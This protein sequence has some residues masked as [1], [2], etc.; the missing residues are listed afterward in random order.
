MLPGF[1]AGDVRWSHHHSH[2]ADRVR[3]PG[4]FVCLASGLYATRNLPVSAI[5]LTLAAAPLFGDRFAE[6]SAEGPSQAS[7]SYLSALSARMGATER[8]MTGHV[9]AVFVPF[10]G[11]AVAL[12]GGKFGERQVMSANFSDQRF[13]V[14]AVDV[15]AQRHIP[16]PIFAP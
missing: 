13:P 2:Q 8:R 16:G 3:S 6:T 1:V 14:Q 7:R 11:V 10:L 4:D 15:I 9:W 5:L 12:H